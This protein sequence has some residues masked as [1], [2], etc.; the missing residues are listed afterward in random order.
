M[1]RFM[2]VV[3]LVVL[4]YVLS[5]LVVGLVSIPI[6]WSSDI[7][8]NASDMFMVVMLTVYLVAFIIKE[9]VIGE[10]K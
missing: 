1:K 10:V 8:A 7:I 9:F 6:T 2:E 5:G 4:V 3:V